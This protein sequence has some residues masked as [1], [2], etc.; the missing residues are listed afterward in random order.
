MPLLALEDTEVGTFLGLLVEDVGLLELVSQSTLYLEAGVEIDL[1]FGVA[2]VHDVQDGVLAVFVFVAAPVAVVL[3]PTVVPVLS[4]QQGVGSRRDG[5]AVETAAFVRAIRLTSVGFG[6]IFDQVEALNLLDSFRVL[7]IERVNSCLVF[8]SWLVAVVPSP[9]VVTG[10]VR[11]NVDGV[12]D[13]ARDTLTKL[14]FDIEALKDAGG[15]GV[16][17]V[18]GDKLG[19]IAAV[20]FKF[21]I[22]AHHVKSVTNQNIHSVLLYKHFDG[23]AIHGQVV[24]FLRFLGIFEVEQGETFVGVQVEHHVAK[25][26]VQVGFL[27]GACS[28][29]GSTLVRRVISCTAVCIWC[30]VRGCSGLRATFTVSA[31]TVGAAVAVATFVRD[32]VGLTLFVRRV[33]IRWIGWGEGAIS[34]SC[35]R[36]Q[37]CEQS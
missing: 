23:V 11:H 20:E 34:T 8:G 36:E 17:D 2:D 27:Y 16:G 5:D 25:G 31:A 35:G 1:S 4:N 9:V 6:S 15:L 7:Y 13:L 18:D 26:T 10:S 28:T 29:G 12:V 30:C 19:Y 3:V 32:K 22:G 33:D 14:T 37:Q 21:S 24:E